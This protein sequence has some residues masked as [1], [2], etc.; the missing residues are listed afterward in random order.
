MRRFASRIWMVAALFFLLL[1]TSLIYRASNPMHWSFWAKI[2]DAQTLLAVEH[3]QREGFLKSNFLWI[4]QKWTHLGHYFDEPKLQHLAQGVWFNDEDGNITARRIYTHYPSWYAV[5]FGI[6]TKLGFSVENK[7]PYQVLAIV[8]SVIGVIF[9]Y[10]FSLLLWPRH[11]FALL[12]S[13]GYVLTGGFLS[14]CDSLANMP[15]DDVGRFG[16]MYYWTLSLRQS[17]RRPYLLSCV[18]LFFGCLTSL[19]SFAYMVLFGGG[20][21]L[22]E[23]RLE[24]RRIA[25]LTL[26]PTAAALICFGQN[27]AYLGL[28]DAIRDWTQTVADR[29]RVTSPTVIQVLVTRITS[30]LHN[31]DRTVKFS[32]AWLI[33]MLG[34]SLWF[35]K[36]TA[37]TALLPVLALI[38]AGLAYAVLF[39]ARAIMPYQTR[40]L[41]PLLVLIN[42]ILIL[43]ALDALRKR[44]RFIEARTIGPVV[45]IALGLYSFYH[46]AEPRRIFFQNPSIPEAQKFEPLYQAIK[47]AV[48]ERVVLASSEA[49]KPLMF[50]PDRFQVS[51]LIEYLSASTFAC[52]SDLE[53]ALKDLHFLWQKREYDFSPFILTRTSEAEELEESRMG[54]IFPARLESKAITANDFVLH[55]VSF[56]PT[57]EQILSQTSDKTLSQN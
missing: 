10:R 46:H 14:Y 22:L 4:P 35:F 56:E 50:R 28:D 40:Q 26:L 42:G 8:L 17:D 15:I 32:L 49:C 54:M 18:F 45:A 11:D 27:V 38:P 19:D 47:G 12:V 39:P 7:F 9:L 6:L 33:P 41:T 2:G 53:T 51:P 34:L 36:R 44:R 52:V 21:M 43:G 55:R 24:G 23:R 20:L 57:R 3:W 13:L 48:G 16:F 29:A 30:V 37:T 1:A 31:V 5:P 25:C